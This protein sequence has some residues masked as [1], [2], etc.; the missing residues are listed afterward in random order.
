MIRSVL[1]AIFANAI[2]TKKY[3]KQIFIKKGDRVNLNLKELFD[4]HHKEPKPGVPFSPL[5]YRVEGNVGRMTGS[6]EVYAGRLAESTTNCYG[7]KT[8]YERVVVNCGHLDYYVVD[9]LGP[10]MRYSSSFKRKGLKALDFDW[11][12]T[13]DS[14]GVVSRQE[15]GRV[16]FDLIRVGEVK[17]VNGT[18]Q[19]GENAKIISFL[20]SPSFIYVAY[21]KTLLTDKLSGSNVLHYID[22]LDGTA[23]TMTLTKAE[24]FL[25]DV[26]Y[27]LDIQTTYMGAMYFSYLSPGTRIPSLVRCQAD[28]STREPPFLNF[29][30]CMKYNTTENFNS[31]GTF[32]VDTRLNGYEKVHFYNKETNHM[33]LCILGTYPHDNPKLYNCQSTVKPI[34]L[35]ERRVFE[36]I[37]MAPFQGIILNFVDRELL[38]QSGPRD[39][40]VVFNLTSESGKPLIF[41]QVS[42]NGVAALGGMNDTLFV[43]R[44]NHY[45]TY[46]M[47]PDKFGLI[48]TSEDFP[49][50]Y[51]VISIE[52]YDH[53][54]PKRYRKVS[55]KVLN[56]IHSFSSLNPIPKIQNFIDKNTRQLLPISRYSFNGNN[57]V[58]K[59]SQPDLF[60]QLY[61][62][63]LQINKED[64]G[65]Q[66]WF[67]SPTEGVSLKDGVLASFDC[68][69]HIGIAS[70]T[71]QRSQYNSI[72][73]QTDHKII[74]ASSN[75]FPQEEGMILAS[76]KKKTVSFYYFGI[77]QEEVYRKTIQTEQQV[78]EGDIWFKITGKLYTFWIIQ[79][80]QIALY[81]AYNKELTAMPI[82]PSTYIK[83]SS[84]KGNTNFCPKSIL[85]C[86][87]HP[88]NV[89]VFSNCNGDARIFNFNTSNPDQMKFTHQ[90]PI[91]SIIAPSKQIQA[92]AIGPETIVLDQGKGILFSKDSDGE[93]SYS[94]IST[95]EA[96]FKTVSSLFCVRNQ[97]AVVISGKG[98]KGE[99]LVS[100][101][102][103]NMHLD[104]RNRFHS[105]FKVDGDVTRVNQAGSQ[106][107]IVTTS[108]GNGESFYR[109]YL[110]GPFIFY[111]A[112]NRTSNRF[113]FSLMNGKEEIDSQDLFLMDQKFEQ[114]ITIERTNTRNATTGIYEF[115]SLATVAG[116][117][118]NIDIQDSPEV[119]L[120]PRL[121]QDQQYLGANQSALNLHEP[122]FIIHSGKYGVG[123]R[124]FSVSTLVYF[125]R[126]YDQFWFKQDMGVLCS[127]VSVTI[128]RNDYAIAAMSTDEGGEYHLRW[129]IKSFSQGSSRGMI[130]KDIKVEKVEIV[131][132]DPTHFAVLA[133][134]KKTSHTSIYILKVSNGE[135]GN[136]WVSQKNQTSTIPNGKFTNYIYF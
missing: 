118:F 33:K 28:T 44:N 24:G 93:Y 136:Y 81:T 36:S 39:M 45:S 16:R 64:L 134:S 60:D 115:F 26:Q 72:K 2:T 59:F 84:I 53:E 88:T 112:V 21:E 15:N 7:A 99:N 116:P 61:L 126:N 34:Q 50:G 104:S 74:Y 133:L 94:E 102:H 110:S 38:G 117:I 37:V 122:D 4:P 32:A 69:G 63:N 128:V 56:D 5:S 114:N 22:F 121:L 119:L 97:Q 90:N 6:N 9:P 113:T 101:I 52:K 42:L 1:L 35:P 91:S 107:L 40:T 58:F 76:S 109:A 125:Y 83:S 87:R 86:P 12:N 78:K 66:I 13:F 70:L 46:Q 68:H 27:L 18:S 10:D 106:G 55:V 31:E 92:C 51:G 48:L 57:P 43:L 82:Y 85:N 29:T 96:G 8:Y 103:G 120:T 19:I 131:Q 65:S 14:L 79:Q 100:V 71:C 54:N 127:A 105:T 123:F 132:I 23:N 130:H 25:D 111:Q 124:T 135:D 73:L 11:Q 108:G 3:D 17:I 98:L 67:I 49:K 30:K 62:N 47:V 89:H 80:N 77:Q 95:Q 129:F 20:N 75:D 41:D